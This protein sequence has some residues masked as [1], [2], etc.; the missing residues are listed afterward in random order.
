MATGETCPIGRFH[1]GQRDAMI[2][3]AAMRVT[4]RLRKLTPDQRRRIIEQL[5][6]GLGV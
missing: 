5:R 4:G 6:L 3:A 1:R 2:D